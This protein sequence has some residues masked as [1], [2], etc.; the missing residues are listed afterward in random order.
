M[1]YG[2]RACSWL[3]AFLTSAGCAKTHKSQPQ[4]VRSDILS[5]SGSIH[6]FHTLQGD[7]GHVITTGGKAHRIALPIAQ[8]L[9]HSLVY[10]VYRPHIVSEDNCGAD[11]SG[12]A[13]FVIS[14]SVSASSIHRVR[15]RT[16]NPAA[17]PLSPLRQR[18]PPQHRSP[19]PAG[20][21][22]SR[23]ATVGPGLAPAGSR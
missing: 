23:T 1:C 6:G 11:R 7:C 8:A 18:C 9:V 13:L 2:K 3:L 21:R 20:A 15:G 19:P 22:R 16:S 14:L 10:S 4:L 17:R 5:A 12:G